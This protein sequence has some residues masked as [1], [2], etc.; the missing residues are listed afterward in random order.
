ML[1]NCSIRD[2]HD[3][4]TPL[5]RGPLLVYNIKCGGEKGNKE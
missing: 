4:W 3:R 5:G 1:V 2:N